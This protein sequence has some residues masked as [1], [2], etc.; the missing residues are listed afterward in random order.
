[1][2]LQD[3]REAITAATKDTSEN[4]R[5]LAFAGI[6]AV[7]LFSGASANAAELRFPALLLWAATLL[8]AALL[9]D[10]LQLV[11][12][13]A[14]SQIFFW[15]KERKQTKE[16]DDSIR[17]PSWFH[18]P[19]HFFFAGKILLTVSAYVLIGLYLL[20]KISVA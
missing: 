5:K 1:M 2:Q 7:W 10:L 17:Y 4:V 14:S 13:S 18:R 3:L 8:I 12:R 15:L 16:K 19:S 6:A 11:Y 9:A 20:Q